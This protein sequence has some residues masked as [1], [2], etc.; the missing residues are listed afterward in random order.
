MTEFFL[1]TSLRSMKR[2]P[3]MQISGGG[4]KQPAMRMC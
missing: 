4:A 3:F 1:S 2:Q